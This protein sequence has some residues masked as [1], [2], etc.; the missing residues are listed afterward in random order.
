LEGVSRFLN[1]AVLI[2]FG[3]FA[4]LATLWILG[5]RKIDFQH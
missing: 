4:Y 1:L 2:G 3:I 5:L